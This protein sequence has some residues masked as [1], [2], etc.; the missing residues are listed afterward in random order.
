MAEFTAG[1]HEVEVVRDS[2]N[3]KR[4][5]VNV[6]DSEGNVV[7]PLTREWFTTQGR[8]EF[9][10]LMP[11]SFPDA[12]AIDATYGEVSQVDNIIE[13]MRDPNNNGY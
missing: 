1:D 7:P 9:L 10:R 4:W 12:N 3:P 11:S 2:G 8:D 5:I 6:R 13:Y